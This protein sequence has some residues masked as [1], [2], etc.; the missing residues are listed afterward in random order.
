MNRFLR[1]FALFALAF[2]ALSGCG[3]AESGSTVP[4]APTT[5]FT[6]SAESALAAARARWEAADIDTY[7]LEFENDCGECG[8]ELVKPRQA[9]VWDG[10]LVDATEQVMSV[11]AVMD[12]ID[13][14]IAAGQSVEVSYDSEYGYPTEV[15]IDREARAYDGGVHWI[16]DG[17]TAGLPGDPASLIKLE[18]AQRQW[19]TVR[20]QA[21]E[22][23]M[24][25]VCDCPFSGRMWITV[26]GDRIVDWNT[27]F[28]E[29]GEMSVS[30]LTMDDMF[31]DLADM[32]EA[33]SIEDSGV[34]FSG[35]AQYDPVLGFPSWIG[36]DI[37]VI[38]P[39]S[40]L[41]FLEPRFIFTVNDFKAVDPQPNP[42]YQDLD[43]ARLNWMTTGLEDYTY[44][45]SQLEV[46]GDLP[47]NEDGS[48]ADPYLVSVENGEVVSVKRFGVE[49]ETPGDVP[50]WTIPQ[51]FDLIE[52]WRQ[53]GLKVEALFSAENGHPV[54]VSAF[55]GTTGHQFFTIRNLEATG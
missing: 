23:R 6:E 39:G 24:S 37:E 36:L 16:L 48:F 38:D 9:V 50:I 7:H 8:P 29:S 53:S 55:D 27:E 14:A 13:R 47:L 46:D 51:L 44:E 35:A 28:D 18:A 4:S 54:I 17:L 43:N 31:E 30:P 22:Y 11:E 42:S 40:E 20:P 12:S 15:W 10:D 33:G 19:D 52:L 5:T 26:D 2:L 41:A 32:F 34:R 1:R 21:Y 25:F 45:L 3:G 49:S